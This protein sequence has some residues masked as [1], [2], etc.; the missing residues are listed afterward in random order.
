M[1]TPQ[2]GILLPLPPFARYLTFTL[3]PEA[4]IATGLKA[5]ADVVDGRDTVAGIGLAPLSALNI[6]VPGLRAFPALSGP[7]VD[8]PAT[9]AALWLWLRGEDRG[10]LLHRARRLEAALA[11]VFRPDECWDA[12]KHA[13]GRD[14]SGYEDGTENPQGEAAA[15]AALAADGSSLVAVQRWQHDFARFEAMAPADQDASIGRRRADNVELIDAPE[16]AHVKRTAQES[17]SPEAFVLRRSMPW[18]EGRAAGLLFVAFG[19][20][21]NPFEAQM[22]RMLGLEDGIVDALFR[23]TRPRSGAY[24]WCPGMQD[25]KLALPG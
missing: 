13:D 18:V 9:P 3:L 6:T 21:L 24:F 12:F 2:A 1:T 5:L 10:E 8:L 4:D 16:S 22:K 20:T 17:F 7:G 11:T 15:A 19:A 25:G 14:L 23:F